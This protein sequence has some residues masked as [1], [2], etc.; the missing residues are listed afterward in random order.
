MDLDAAWTG[1]SGRGVKPTR[2]TLSGRPRRPIA[3]LDFRRLLQTADRR[4]A[5]WQLCPVSHVVPILAG[6]PHETAQFHEPSHRRTG[7]GRSRRA[8]SNRRCR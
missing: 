7:I 1:N 3:A 4:A 2:L 8:R 5:M 6:R